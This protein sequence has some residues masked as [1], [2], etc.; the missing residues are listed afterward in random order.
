M[1][2]GVKYHLSTMSG[3]P[4]LS[5]SAG[6]LIT[7]LDACLVNGFGSVTL[8][9][10]VVEDDVATATVSAGHGFT[11]YVSTIGPVITIAGA[12]P[13]GLNGEFRINVT[14]STVFTFATSGIDDQ[15]AT[16]TIT[17]NRSPI[18]FA[19]TY[20][21]T[22]LAAYQCTDAQGTQFFMR[23]DDTTTT[24]ATITCYESMSDINTGTNMFGITLYIRKSNNANSNSRAW[25]IFGD[26][27]AFYF[28][29]YWNTVMGSE[30]TF[31]GDIVSAANAADG[32]ECA[33]IS[34]TSNSS[35]YPGGNEGGINEFR[36]L[37]GSAGHYLA[38]AYD[39]TKNRLFLKY[40]HNRAGSSTIG[41]GAGVANPCTVTGGLDLSSV[42][43]FET[44]TLFRGKMPGLWSCFQALPGSDGDVY[45]GNPV[46]VGIK[47]NYGNNTDNARALM[48]IYPDWR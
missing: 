4:T 14:S 3:A 28:F 8:T 5:G 35:P 43:V 6:A 30:G 41:Y 44:S 36:T 32:Y 12:T 34:T 2:T 21:G 46:I 39:G 16:G 10:L 22:N 37:A 25:K 47:L 42:E 11:N 15:T 9:S 31:F 17:A 1:D 13:S 24:Y 26:S 7:V 45:D 23:V 33:I 20:S 40:T 19:K 38:R 29:P 18:G 48:Q 27:R